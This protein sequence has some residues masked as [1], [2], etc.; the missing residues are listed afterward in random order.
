MWP[1]MPVAPSVS[2]HELLNWLGWLL[3]PGWARRGV[4]L[5]PKACLPCGVLALA[6]S[7]VVARG[8]ALSVTSVNVLPGA[9]DGIVVSGT[10]AGESTYG[11]VVMAEITP[12]PGNTGTVTFTLAP[13]VDVTQV[14]DVWPAAGMFTP[15]DTDASGSVAL[16]GAVDDDG[17]FVPAPVSFNGALVRL[18]IIAGPDAAGV[19]DVSLTTSLGASAWEG[20]ATVLVNGTVTVTAP[21][22]QLHTDCDDGDPCTTDTCV[23]GT[24]QHTPAEGV[25]GSVP[26]VGDA[27][28]VVLVALLIVCG[29]G[30][31]SGRARCRTRPSGTT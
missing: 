6:M 8:A 15:L 22:C 30:V 31:I 20:L 9:T 17:N 10:I 11:V 28:A 2:S 3:S 21:P 14:T 23:D 5:K 12:R 13:P 24:C 29:A 27:G 1:E 7:A 18:P 25:C 4:V 19:W 26:A 16:N